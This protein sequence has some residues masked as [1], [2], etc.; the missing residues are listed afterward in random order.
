MNIKKAMIL[1]GATAAGLVGASTAASADQITIKSGD[2][3]AG[4]AQEHGT[5]T[6]NLAAI[7]AITDP[8]LIFAG[9]TLETEG[10]AAPVAAPA[11]QAPVQAAAPVAQPAATQA[12]AA[13]VQKSA[14]PAQVSAPAGSGS[15]YEEFIANGGTAAM[16]HTIVRPESGGNPNAISPNGYRGLGQTKEGW[17]TGSVAQQTK[18]MVN[19]ATSRYGSVENAISFRQANGWW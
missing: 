8:N 16:W 7:N 6:E 4:I 9:E 13:P 3:L 2:T 1:T 11:Q 17:G 14:A 12:P 19:Y 15:T 10:Q 18:G 5:T